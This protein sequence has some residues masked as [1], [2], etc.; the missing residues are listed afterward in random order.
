MGRL[1]AMKFGSAQYW[2]F[3]VYRGLGEEVE[4]AVEAVEA[5][6]VGEGSRN[7]LGGS[8]ARQAQSTKLL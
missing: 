7:V 4:E 6:L 1:T 3:C 8:R 5:V 2:R